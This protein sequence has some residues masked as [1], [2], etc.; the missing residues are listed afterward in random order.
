MFLG[1]IVFFLVPIRGTGD[2]DAT[3]SVCRYKQQQHSGQQ[4]MGNKQAI[5][6]RATANASSKEC[7][8]QQKKVVR[9]KN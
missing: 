6:E 3:N 7:L 5:N 2:N 9:C 1:E 8:F 4:S